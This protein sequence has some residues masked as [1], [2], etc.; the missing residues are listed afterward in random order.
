MKNAISILNQI[1]KNYQ[2]KETESV[3]RVYD[4]A[5][6][7]EN[8]ELAKKLKNFVTDWGNFSIQDELDEL[9]NIDDAD[10]FSIDSTISTIKIIKS[11]SPY[12]FF[13]TQNG[14]TSHLKNGNSF[15]NI[16]AI[17]IPFTK[18]PFSTNHIRFSVEFESIQESEKEKLEVIKY[19]KPLNAESQLILPNDINAW[20]TSE[21]DIECAIDC[22]K[23]VSTLKL[24][25]AISAEIFKEGN[26]IELYFRGERRKKLTLD[27]SNAELLKTIF[28]VSTNCANWIYGQSKDIDTRHGIFNHQLSILLPDSPK[29]SDLLSVFES[30]L[31]NSK[32]AYRYHLQSNNKELNKTLTDLNKT[33]FDYITKIR[34]NTTDLMT[35]AWRDLS[36]VLGLM[37]LNFSLKKPDLPDKIYDYLAVALCIYLTVSIILTGRVSFCYYKNLM[38]GLKDWRAKIYGY[39]N[40][41]EFNT[42]AYN[43]LQLAHEKYKSTFIVVCVLYSLMILFIILFS[44]DLVKF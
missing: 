43:P 24:L 26:Q 14:F 2:I 17:N 3:L 34:Q 36:T 21:N 5:L 9:V 16:F 25:C 44:F 32:L 39:L 13:L 35:S 22:W 23:E 37:L 19:V 7:I 29:E 4:Y 12:L 28:N 15:D 8:I 41:E 20:I 38:T 11:N 42:F 30:A 31:D 6:N 1:A 10:T 27:I 33:L 18:K 40:D